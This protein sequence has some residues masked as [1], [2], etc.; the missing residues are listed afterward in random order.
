ME[1][2]QLADAREAVEGEFQDTV[3]VSTI[4]YEDDGEG[5]RTNTG[6][7]EIYSGAGSLQ[8]LSS[9]EEAVIANRL[10]GRA[11]YRL[12]L[13][14][15]VDPDQSGNLTVNGDEYEILSGFGGEHRATHTRFILAKIT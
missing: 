10:E 4:T 12:K 9:G 6:T 15:T 7:T 8:R 3:V 11:G 5:G 1:A 13:P 14:H 2:D